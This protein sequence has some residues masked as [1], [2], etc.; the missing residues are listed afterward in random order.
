MRYFAL[1]ACLF[2]SGCGST[3]DTARH[4]ETQTVEHVDGDLILTLPIAGIPVPLPVHV[5]VTRTVSTEKNGT[6]HEEK[7]LVLPD[8]GPLLAIVG[9]LG[10]GAANAATGGAGGNIALAISAA[11]TAL[12]GGVA[13]YKTAKAGS[14]R[15]RADTHAANEDEVYQDFKQAMRGKQ[16]PA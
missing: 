12:A 16:A 13:A 7:K 2:L 4:E 11:M 5:S 15:Q 9:K 3:R 8:M 14:E 10:L 1:I 6:Q